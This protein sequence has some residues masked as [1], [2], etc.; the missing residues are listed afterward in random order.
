MVSKDVLDQRTL[1]HWRAFDT[2]HYRKRYW[3]TRLIAVPNGKKSKDETIRRREPKPVFAGYGS[4]SET[5]KRSVDDDRLAIL[6][7]LKVQSN[8]FRNIRDFIG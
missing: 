2:T 6:S 8:P 4:V 5:G 1:V 3:G 7:L